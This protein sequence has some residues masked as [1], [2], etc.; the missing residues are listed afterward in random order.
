[1]DIMKIK[2]E[3]YIP[4]SC[5][6]TLVQALN[7]IGALK[8]GNYDSCICCYKVNGFWKPLEGS[9]P[10]IGKMNKLSS[11]EELKVEFKSRYSLM[12]EI[13]STIKQVHP[14]EE[15]VINIFPLLY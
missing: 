12:E 10:F 14:Y 4:E 11:E 2:V 6:G 1:M 3:T 8:I 13:Y 5:F 7:K 15:P 9:T